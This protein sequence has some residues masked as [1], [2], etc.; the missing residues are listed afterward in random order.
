[1]VR[2]LSPWFANVGKRHVKAPKVYIRD[3]GLLHGLLNLRTL[4]DLLGH[5]K[6]GASWEGFVIEQLVTHLRAQP[7]ECYF[8]ATHAGAELDLLILRGRQRLGF[9]VKRTSSPSLTPSMRAALTDLGLQR[10]DV[11]HAGDETF[12]LAKNVRAV[13]LQRLL[14]DV[15]GFS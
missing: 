1:V 11:I 8:W 7:E 2:Q 9:E 6:L 4:D 14:A 5:P 12:Q 3:P 15:R 10:L 13:A